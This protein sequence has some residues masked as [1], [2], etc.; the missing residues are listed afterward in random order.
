MGFNMATF[1][2]VMM[3]WLNVFLTVIE[4]SMTQLTLLECPPLNNAAHVEETATDLE[5]VQR[6]LIIFLLDS[7]RL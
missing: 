1:N 4:V 3:W 7:E 2:I 5:E 6:S